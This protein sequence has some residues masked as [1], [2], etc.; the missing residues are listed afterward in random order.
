MA[1][2]A[3]YGL[4]ARRAHI[5]RQGA[6]V[7]GAEGVDVESATACVAGVD[8]EFDRLAAGP[9]VH[10]EA[11]HALLMEFVVVAKTDQILQQ[12]LL[13]DLRAGVLNLHTAPVG[14]ASDEAIAFE[15]VAG[16]GFGDWRFFMVGAQQLGGGLV[17]RA[18]YI[19]AVQQQAFELLNAQG[20]KLIAGQ[21]AHANAARDRRAAPDSF[22][23]IGAQL[24]L[25]FADVAKEA[26]VE[27]VQVELE[28]LALHQIRRFAGNREMHQGYLGLAAQVQPRQLIGRPQVSAKK[29]GVGAS[30]NFF[31]LGQAGQREQQRRVV[32]VNIG[33]G[34]AQLGLFR[35]IHDQNEQPAA[36]SLRLGSNKYVQTLLK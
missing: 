9:D 26:V 32:L 24:G 21:K 2:E 36:Y 11:F 27:A 17:L 33:R 14:L 13:V 6:G 28:G 22:G 4:L 19:E 5:G 15:Q 25:D 1:S 23:D 20:L 35:S 7:A 34:L 3:A 18:L 8:R 30:A 16:Q 12:T 31:A 29:R 10:E